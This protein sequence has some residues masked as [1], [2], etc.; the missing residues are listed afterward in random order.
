[1]IAALILFLV[2]GFVAFLIALRLR[3]FRRPVAW[4]VGSVPAL[5]LV[6]T[7]LSGLGDPLVLL[8]LMLFWVPSLLGAH[9]G[10]ELACRLA[11]WREAR[12]AT[13]ASGPP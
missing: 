13:S 3:R 12:R 6:L 5:L 8:Y 11:A 7:N 9:A 10:V 4:T 2:P 1:M